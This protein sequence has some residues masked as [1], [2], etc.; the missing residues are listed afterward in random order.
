MRFFA[1]EHVFKI[2]SLVDEMFIDS[3]QVL[4]LIHSIKLAVNVRP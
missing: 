3:F 2:I 4:D 1:I